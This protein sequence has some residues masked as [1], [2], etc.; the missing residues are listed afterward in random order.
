MNPIQSQSDLVLQ[1]VRGGAAEKEAALQQLTEITERE[2]V[3]TQAPPGGIPGLP[4][5][6]EAR[7][8]QYGIPNDAFKIQAAFNVCLVKQVSWVEGEKIGS[9]FLPKTMQ[10]KNEEEAPRG[11]LVSAGLQALDCL[12]SNGID[13]GHMVSML[14]LAPWRM[15]VEIVAGKYEYLLILRTGDITGS[16]DLRVALA[17]GKCRIHYDEE[18]G[19]HLYVDENGKRWTPTLPFIPEDY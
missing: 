13:L 2:V 18:H 3:A 15:P 14:R 8:L 4:P 5:L 19:Q 11:I 16:E 7:R 1:Y 6:L 17:E 12:R 10:K 9:I